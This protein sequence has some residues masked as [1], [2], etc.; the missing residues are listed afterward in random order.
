MSDENVIGTSTSTTVTVK[1]C[2]DPFSQGDLL[3]WKCAYEKAKEH[4]QSI[5]NQS[6]IDLIDSA[7]CYNSLGATNAKLKN[8]EEAINNYHQQLDILRK[9]KPSEKVT[10]DIV[11]CYTSIGKIYCL[12][13][14]YV[15]AIDHYKQALD[16][17]STI[18]ST[19]DLISNI[20]KDLA[21]LYTKT[22]E[23][24]LATNYF[25]KA[26]EIDHQQLGQYHPKFGQTYANMG[27]MYYHQQDYKQA[28][29]YFLKAHDVWEK[30]LTSSHIYTES[31]RN[32]IRTI[33]LKLSMYLTS[34]L[35]QFGSPILDLP[36][37]E[38]D[39]R[40]APDPNYPG[41]VHASLIS[42]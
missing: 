19:S 4:F 36:T 20:Y 17:V 16:L 37:I 25:T 30:S 5:L 23:F 7:R 24:D 8:Y 31:M 6:S 13:Q 41:S 38:L 2:D 39:I 42:K 40:H 18:T 1:K 26:F 11:K 32:Q 3:Y 12:K 10:T 29:Y 33:E 34:I 21:N 27:A 14:D 35:R 22:Q 9:L 15:V 28:L